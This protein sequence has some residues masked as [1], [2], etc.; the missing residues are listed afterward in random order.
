[1][2]FQNISVGWRHPSFFLVLTKGNFWH[3]LL[4]KVRRFVQISLIGIL[5]ILPDLAVFVHCGRLSSILFLLFYACIYGFILWINDLYQKFLC[6]QIIR[7]MMSIIIFW[8]LFL[9][10]QA[11][12]NN[13]ACFCSCYKFY[14]LIFD[15]CFQTNFR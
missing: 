2:I 8:H 6:C 14:M 1:M 13:F 11:L 9:I 7:N 12:Q 10:I 15:W 5:L 3:H 4:P